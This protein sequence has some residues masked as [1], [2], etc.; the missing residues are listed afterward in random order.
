MPSAFQKLKY[1]Y[2]KV[3]SKTYVK[4]TQPNEKETP[5]KDDLSMQ[6]YLYTH[7]NFEHIVKSTGQ[8]NIYLHTHNY[9]KCRKE[10]K[11]VHKG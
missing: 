4:I 5:K 7:P 8:P 2:R 1:L 10:K 9:A 11:V 3:D 6:I